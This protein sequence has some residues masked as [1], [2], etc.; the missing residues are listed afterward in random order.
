MDNTAQGVSNKVASQTQTP[1]S[2]PVGVA[3]PQKELGPAILAYVERTDEKPEI[4]AQ[5]KELGV[6]SVS[7]EVEIPYEAKKAGLAPSKQAV[8]AQTM[9]DGTVFIPLTS[10]ESFSI[11]KMHKDITEAIVWLATWCIRQLKMRKD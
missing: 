5:L 9:P 6:E 2:T 10:S 1:V 3:G 4:P 7:D 11:L 8:P